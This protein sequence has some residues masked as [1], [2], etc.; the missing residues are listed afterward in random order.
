MLMYLDS[1]ICGRNEDMSTH[2]PRLDCLLEEKLEKIANA[3][4]I[5]KDDRIEFGNIKVST[6]SAFICMNVDAFFV[7]I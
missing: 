1:L 3:D 2:T 7:C 6:L 4:C 5:V